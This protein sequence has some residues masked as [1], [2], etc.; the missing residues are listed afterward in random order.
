M[1]ESNG[2]LANAVLFVGHPAKPVNV[3]PHSRQM[4]IQ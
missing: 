2:P 4:F 1:V 3:G